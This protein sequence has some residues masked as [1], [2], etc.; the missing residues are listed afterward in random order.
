M[1]EFLMKEGLDTLDSKSYYKFESSGSAFLLGPSTPE[2]YLIKAIS[3]NH[4]I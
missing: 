3:S 4:F 2:M 1:P